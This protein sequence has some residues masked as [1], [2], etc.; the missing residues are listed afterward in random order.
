M[1]VST[2][3]KRQWREEVDKGWND[4]LT[5]SEDDVM[6]RW[7][8]KRLPT[9]ILAGRLGMA[10][11]VLYAER[12]PE[13]AERFLAQC[14]AY[15]SVADAMILADEKCQFIEL[16]R[17]EYYRSK[18]HCAALKHNRTDVESLR[19]ASEYYRAHLSA[20]S[21]RS[22]HD[23]EQGMHMAAVLALLICGDTQAAHEMADRARPP[24][25]YHP[26]A[27]P[28]K[29]LCTH[30]AQGQSVPE[31]VVLVLESH[32][33]TIRDPN[34]RPQR[35]LSVTQFRFELGA[36]LWKYVHHPDAKEIDGPS[37]VA[38]VSR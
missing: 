28:I 14:F 30:V 7:N 38:Y 22:W 21:C 9:A 37:V 8:R 17:A 12:D 3:L 18:A 34:Y 10:L 4:L 23:L 25:W 15:V 19:V 26:E 13:I 36:V 5:L 11:E 33:D 2:S 24:Q 6:S 27:L 31:D 32:F 29:T 35:L 1:I 20:K 16:D